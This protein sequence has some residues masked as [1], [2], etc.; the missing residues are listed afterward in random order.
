MT[1]GE[2]G[3]SGR[4]QPAWHHLP[5]PNVSSVRGTQH[6][7]VVL[8]GPDFRRARAPLPKAGSLR[9]KP[10]EE[11]E[12]ETPPR[13]LT[14]SSQD[15]PRPPSAG[16]S[17]ATSRRALPCPHTSRPDDLRRMEHER[18]C[19]TPQIKDVEEQSGGT[20]EMVVECSLLP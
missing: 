16:A 1:P 19:N 4:S 20:G 12:K 17:R 3:R 15:C 7:P 8:L 10:P 14:P 6:L 5:P 18:S 9:T 11:M 2:N 13:P